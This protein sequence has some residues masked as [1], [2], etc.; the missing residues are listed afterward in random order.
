MDNALQTLLYP[1]EH[2]L[3]EAPGSGARVAFL[4]ARYHPALKGFNAEY[5]FLHQYFRPY[6]LELLNHGFKPE[7]VI[8][9]GAEYDLVL[10]LLPKNADEARYV[11]AS[12]L[13][14]LKRN[15]ILLAAADNRAGGSRIARIYEGFGVSGPQEASKNKAR[16]VWGARPEKLSEA[17]KTA[18][19]AGEMQ[20]I[21]GGMF[22]SV[23]GIFGWDKVDRGSALLAEHIPSDLKGTGADFGC[24]YGY[25]SCHIL[26]NCPEIKALICSDADY[27]ALLACKGNTSKINN[28]AKIS[29]FWEDLTGRQTHYDLDW[30][31]MNPPFHEGK[32]SDPGIGGAFIQQ[33]AKALRP[34]GRLYMVANVQLPYEDI[35]TQNFARVEKRH[36]GGGF[37]VFEA[38]K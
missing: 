37:K 26:E 6:A 19:T 11:V 27:R 3:L 25:L 30:V 24:G 4:N 15:G 35:L 16:V 33:A 8:K 20:D 9:V 10:A 34:G 12:G 32:Q 29:R 28:L 21:P 18:L 1:F 38:V 5:L 2:G 36:E 22:V 13:N 31:V 23:P 7:P 14:M 17:L